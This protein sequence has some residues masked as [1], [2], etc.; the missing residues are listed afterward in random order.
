[1]SYAGTYGDAETCAHD[2]YRPNC[3]RCNG[4]VER[5]ARELPEREAHVAALTEDPPVTAREVIVY[6]VTCPGCDWTRPGCE[7]HE[8]AEGL[9]RAHCDMARK[10]LAEWKG[11][12][13]MIAEAR[14][15]G[16][17]GEPD[18]AERRVP[19]APSVQPPEVAP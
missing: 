16:L 9:Y 18:A 1:M 19:I 2:S 4:A 17:L 6:D 8:D 14:S 5:F 12:G 15:R 10:V 3:W 7:T 13:P 11:D